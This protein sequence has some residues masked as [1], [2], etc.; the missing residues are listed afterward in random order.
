MWD[1]DGQCTCGRKTYLFGQCL[2]CLAVD[3][4][5]AEQER[6]QAEVEQ[7]E[8][9]SDDDKPIAKLLKSSAMHSLRS[10]VV[11]ARAVPS[12][13]PTLA[14]SKHTTYRDPE[15]GSNDILSSGAQQ[16]QQAQHHG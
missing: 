7:E 5:D 8:Y 15:G 6:A 2:N 10:G 9:D 13:A 14:V 12:T 11:P 16:A 4:Q 1:H 3:R